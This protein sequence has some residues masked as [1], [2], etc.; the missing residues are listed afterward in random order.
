MQKTDILEHPE[1]YNSNQKPKRLIVMLHGVGSDGR[2]LINL[3]PYFDKN[4][5]DSFFISPNGIEPYDMAPFG[6][7]WFSLQDRRPE[8]ILTLIKN[9]AKILEQIISIKQQELSL[10][11]KETILVGFSQG[12]MMS[13]YLT[14]TVS[15]PYNAAILFSGRLVLPAN[16]INK[17]TPFCLIHGK[18]DDIISYEET[19]NMAHYFIQNNINCKKLIIENLTHSIDLQGLEFATD[20][21][22][23]SISV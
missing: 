2:D 12:S 19:E 6:R 3:A 23:N 13:V 5:P 1:F 20:F 10:T 22:K 8:K 11:N 7:Q 4:L 16:I 15:T 14:L 18:E 21:I 9:N 17:S